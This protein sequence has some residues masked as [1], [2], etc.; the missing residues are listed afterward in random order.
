MDKTIWYLMESSVMLACLYALYVLVLRKETF[1]MLNRFYLIGIVLFSLIFPFLSFDFNPAP[2]AKIPIQEISK[3]RTSYY[4]AFADW[5]YVQTSTAPI[6]PSPSLFSEINWIEVALWMLIAVYLIGVVV[7]LSRTVLTMQWIYGL[8]RRHSQA[9]FDNIKIVKLKNPMAPFSFLNYVFVHEEMIG[10]TEF[11]HILAHERTHVQQL[12]SL[13][14]IFVQLLAAFFWFNPVIWRLIKSLKTTHEYIADNNILNEG[15]SLVQYQTLLLRQLISNNSY[16]LVHN[17]NLS[18]IKKRITMMKNKKSGGFGKVKVA[19]ALAFTI[20]FS[21]VMIQCNSTTDEAEVDNTGLA[22]S[23]ELPKVQ[24]VGY[25]KY[26]GKNYN[27]I[28]FNITNSQVY[29]KSTPTAIKDIESALQK[30]NIQSDDIVLLEINKNQTMGFV[31]EVQDELRRLNQRKILYVSESES[32]KL[33]ETAILLPPLPGD[34]RP[35]VPQLPKIDEEYIAKTGIDILKINL[36]EDAG[37]TNQDLVNAMVRKHIEMGSTNYCVSAKFEDDDTYDSYLR[38]L[39]YIM[40]G[41]DV[42]YQER[43]SEMFGVNF[44]ELDKNNPTELAQYQ[45]IRKGIPR[46][47]SIAEK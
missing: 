35:G 16:G 41:F 6:A 38:N 1:F 3:A 23:F 36:G 39:I 34:D 25:T 19:G 42:I 12:H 20:V 8:I 15:Y 18:F 14:L 9:L 24:D 31:R 21:L 33:I 29:Q 5:T 27:I 2:V 28:P 30:A 46:A 17:F 32:G 47:I 7:C 10:T 37:K 22:S 45:A 40:E 43:A 4:D 26:L 11:D 44:F 13:D